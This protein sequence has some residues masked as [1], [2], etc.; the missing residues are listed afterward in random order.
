LL[1]EIKEIVF[2]QIFESKLQD[3]LSVFF[4]FIVVVGFFVIFSWKEK[5]EKTPTFRAPRF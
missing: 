3:Y 4:N 1:E 5:E 2:Q